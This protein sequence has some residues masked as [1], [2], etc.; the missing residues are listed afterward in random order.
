MT[1]V[2]VS[3]QYAQNYF[4][5]EI[6]RQLCDAADLEGILTAVRAADEAPANLPASLNMFGFE[7]TPWTADNISVLPTHPVIILAAGGLRLRTV[8][9]TGAYSILNAPFEHAGTV[10][11]DDRCFLWRAVPATEV[12]TQPKAMPGSLLF[13][14]PHLH[15]CDQTQRCVSSCS[16]AWP[17]APELCDLL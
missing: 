16:P 11:P 10:L 3:V 2:T 8:F 1:S 7:S 17:S 9:N 5:A 13:L 4:Q 6:P 15:C 14:A 12:L